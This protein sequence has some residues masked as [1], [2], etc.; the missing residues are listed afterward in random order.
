[1][2]LQVVAARDGVGMRGR[3]AAL[4]HRALGERLDDD[5]GRLGIEN[6]VEGRSSG[7]RG[8]DVAT[9]QDV[10]VRVM[11]VRCTTVSHGWL[12]EWGDRTIGRNASGDRSAGCFPSRTLP[13]LEGGASPAD[14]QLL[15]HQNAPAFPSALSNK[16]AWKLIPADA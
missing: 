5:S 13:S 2:A 15:L 7:R 12:L 8:G 10:E 3:A 1:V 14:D 11:A 16:D 6:V 9:F 4:G